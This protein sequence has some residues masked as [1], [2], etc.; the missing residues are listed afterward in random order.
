LETAEIAVQAA[1]TGHLVFSTLHTNDAPGALIRLGN[2]GVEPFLISSSVIGLLA[3]RLARVICP[4]CR[5]WYKPSAE[6]LASLQRGGMTLPP[7]VELARGRGC[8]ECNHVG[9]RGRV[10]VYEVMRMSDRLRELTLARASTVALREQARAEGMQ[11]MQEAG[12]EKVFQGVTTAEEILRVI[13][14]EE[15]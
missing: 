3:Q 7:K 1:L 15:D 12:L 10:A 4:S 2:M 9:Y 13:Y 11:I 5:Q 6:T 14:A 8:E